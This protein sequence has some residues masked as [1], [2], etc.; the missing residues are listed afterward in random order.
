MAFD[1][2][3]MEDILP[4]PGNANMAFDLRP[5]KDVLPWLG[6]ANMA[7]D[8]RPTEDVLPWLGGANIA[9]DLV[10]DL[11]CLLRTW[12]EYGIR[13]MADGGCTS[14]AR[15]LNNHNGMATRTKELISALLGTEAR[16]MCH[17]G[18]CSAA[19]DAGRLLV[20]A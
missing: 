1:L 12:C 4:W 3:P 7:F 11:Q 2:R 14:V 18:R 16:R 15:L 17:A 5:T 20:D 6:Y 10:P 19:H 8:L 9:F 13:L